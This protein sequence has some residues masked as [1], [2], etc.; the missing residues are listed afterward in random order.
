MSQG[1]LLKKGVVVDMTSDDAE[2][3]FWIKLAGQKDSNDL[4]EVVEW[5]R[6]SLT[7][8]EE[9]GPFT[10]SDAYGFFIEEYVLIVPT[11]TDMMHFKMVWMSDL[12]K[13]EY[14]EILRGTP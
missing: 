10:V 4:M 9:H 6:E 7:I 14:D 8:V 2:G 1:T 12:L 5:C 11:K 13:V 3:D